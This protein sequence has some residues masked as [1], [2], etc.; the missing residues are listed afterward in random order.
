MPAAQPEHI[1]G[2]T[3]TAHE[4]VPKGQ[5]DLQIRQPVTV[6]IVPVDICQIFLCACILR[7]CMR[8]LCCLPLLLQTGGCMSPSP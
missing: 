3:C 6:V 7:R 1:H 4:D 2:D 8:L 5:A